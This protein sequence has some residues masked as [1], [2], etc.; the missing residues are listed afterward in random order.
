MTGPRFSVVIPTY[1]R[2]EHVARAVR[3]VR[4]QTFPAHE[5]V[6]VDDGSTDGTADI[7]DALA[8]EDGPPV[9]ALRQ[10]N[11]G[12]GA[13]RNLGIGAAAGDWV[14]LLD[15]DDAWLPGKLEAA[16]RMIGRE[17]GLDFIH[18]RCVQDFGQNFG[19]DFGQ[20][21]GPDGG[22]AAEPP[23]TAEQRCDPAVLLT[24]WHIKTSSVILRRDLLDRIG[25][26]FPT[27][28]R[29]C[30]D[31]ELFWRAAIAA[32]RIGFA[33]EAGTV[34]ANIPTSLSRDETRVLPRLM[35][36]VEALGR[37]I[38]WLDGRAGSARLRPILEARRYW[39]ARVLL[40]R[41]ARDR[42]FVEAVR[43]LRCQDLPPAEI[44]RA[45]LSAGRGVLN[46][47]NPSG[48]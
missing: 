37:V 33:P 22:T 16:R 2:A 38:R 40:T 43:W 27:D 31:F 17:P 23:L 47:E 11:R 32:D 15:S 4:A 48:L 19:Q 1:N 7:L 8:R 25:G 21:P 44:A 14:A 10:A 35:D 28:L 6:V 42:R 34:I 30:E 9:V 24:G 29:T 39:A 41:A 46:G 20:D 45:A 36:N 26:L 12:A 5:I 18:S 13:A 3:S